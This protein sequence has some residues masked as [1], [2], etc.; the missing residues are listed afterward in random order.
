M[1]RRLGHDFQAYQPSSP[2][3]EHQGAPTNMQV[4]SRRG[5]PIPEYHAGTLIPPLDPSLQPKPTLWDPEN[6]HQSQRFSD[7]D[8]I[9]FIHFLKWYLC[10]GSVAHIPDRE[11]LYLLLARQVSIFPSPFLGDEDRCN[12]I[13]RQTPHHNADAWKRHWDDAPELPDKIYIEARKRA[14]D[15]ALARSASLSPSSNEDGSEDDIDAADRDGPL[16]ESTSQ[17]LNQVQRVPYPPCLRK[18]TRKHEK[19]TEEDL[20]EMAQYKYERRDV[21]EQIHSSMAR[22]KEFAQRPEVS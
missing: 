11:E 14:D 17:V 13:A 15:E 22:W 19:V 9:F 21:W 18:K 1:D 2:I 7:E 8:K 20:R 5:G 12:A 3:S 4:R 6:I 10:Q 16:N